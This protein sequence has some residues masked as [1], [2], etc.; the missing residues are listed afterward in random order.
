MPVI[1]NNGHNPYAELENPELKKQ[2]EQENADYDQQVA[3]ATPQ[4]TEQ[5]KKEAG[6]ILGKNFNPETSIIDVSDQEKIDPENQENPDDILKQLD[7]EDFDI[8]DSP[9]STENSENTNIQEPEIVSGSKNFTESNEKQEEQLAKIDSPYTPILQRL[10]ENGELTIQ[11]SNTFLENLQKQDSDTQQQQLFLDF[12]GKN[13]SNKNTLTNLQESFGTQAKEITQENFSQTPFSQEATTINLTLQDPPSGLEFSLAQ[14][15]VSIPQN[16]Q[17]DIAKD[18]DTCMDVTL[19]G[20]IKEND[21]EF[22]ENH[23]Q[24]IEE[25]KTAKNIQEK[26]KKLQNLFKQDILEDAKKFK[27][28]KPQDITERKQQLQEYYTKKIQDEIQKIPDKNI[29]QKIQSTP[30]QQ[31]LVETNLDPKT[32]ECLENIVTYVKKMGIGDTFAGGKLDKSSEK[33]EN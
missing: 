25:I 20:L 4:Q 8:T 29:Q 30:P 28:E 7:N 3:N 16:E 33:I 21:K 1:Q 2:K 23:G 13:I 22:R 12:I 9:K 26:Y 18:M 6:D 17:I 32:K 19:N 14:N 27:I 10:I 24:E 11:T 31:L 15:Y 5:M